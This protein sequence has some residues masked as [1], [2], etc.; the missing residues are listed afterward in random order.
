MTSGTDILRELAHVRA[1]FQLRAIAAIIG[2][3]PPVIHRYGNGK[4]QE[5]PEGEK[6]PGGEAP[7]AE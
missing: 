7:A 2:A 6:I 3:P 5:T 1:T 4:G